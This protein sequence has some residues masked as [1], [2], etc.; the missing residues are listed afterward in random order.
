MLS[1]A[2]RK[3][4]AVLSAGQPARGTELTDDERHAARELQLLTMKPLIYVANVDEQQL[5]DGFRLPGVPENMQVPLSVKMEEEVASLPSEEVREYM[6]ALGLQETG[7]DRLIR[8][9][10]E[11]L[12]LLTYFTSGEVETRAWTVHHGDKA[13]V[14]AGVIHTDFEKNFIRA[15]VINW[16]DFVEFGESGCRDRGKLRIEG[17]DYVMQ[18]GDVC[19]FRVGA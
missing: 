4:F 12:G 10:Y 17:K 16:R 18:D 8:A 6:D 14:A 9:A 13:P 19:H 11:L 15:E 1:E 2:A 3:I 5:K 7:L